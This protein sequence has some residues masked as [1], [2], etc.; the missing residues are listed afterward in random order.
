[1][2]SSRTPSRGSRRPWLSDRDN[3][4]SQ[5][6]AVV[7]KETAEAVPS[8][9]SL[10]SLSYNLVRTLISSWLQVRY[11]APAEPGK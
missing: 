2:E 4:G 10:L 1:M 8:K 5:S 11:H 3:I 9:W 7:G 6:Q